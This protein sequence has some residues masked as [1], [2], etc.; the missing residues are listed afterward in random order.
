MLISSCEHP[1]RRMPIATGSLNGS[2]RYL[3]IHRWMLKFCHY[4]CIISSFLDSLY[5][6]SC[7]WP[8]TLLLGLHTFFRHSLIIGGTAARDAESEN[9]E[10]DKKTVPRTGKRFQELDVLK[11]SLLLLRPSL[12]FFPAFPGI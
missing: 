7:H 4:H 5:E 2:G 10:A 1:Q 6:C 8:S 12:L 3:S 9:T 11:A